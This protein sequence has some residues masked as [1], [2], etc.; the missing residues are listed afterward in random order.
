MLYNPLL[1]VLAALSGILA[2]DASESIDL[3]N[4]SLPRLEPIQYARTDCL[5]IGY[6]DSGP[7]NASNVVLLVHGWPYDINAYYSV[8]PLL[9]ERGF[10]AIVPYLRGFGPTTFLSPT[11]YRTAEQAA[12]GK[13]VIDLMDALGVQKAFVSQA[14]QDRRH[15]MFD[16]FAD[17][18]LI[19][20]V[21]GYDWGTVSVSRS[22]RPETIV[23][24]WASAYSQRL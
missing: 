24:N 22:S 21:A 19:L 7:E 11:S 9:K 1:V 5:N 20:Q 3:V 17:A 13:D 12:L 15:S 4:G 16:A 18:K 14:I 10:R 2:Q 8:V 23:L 6:F